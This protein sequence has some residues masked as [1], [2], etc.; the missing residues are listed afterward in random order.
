MQCLII[1]NNSRQCG[2]VNCFLPAAGNAPYAEFNFQ[3]GRSATINTTDLQIKWEF[4]GVITKL[5]PPN[6]EVRHPRCVGS[7]TKNFVYYTYSRTQLYF[8]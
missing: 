4:S 5:C 1:G 2:T 6:L 3:R 7:K 8:T